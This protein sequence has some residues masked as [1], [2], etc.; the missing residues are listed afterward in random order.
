MCFEDHETAQKILLC[1][2]PKE[3]KRL[4]R[5]VRNFDEDIWESKCYD[6]VRR[7]NMLKV[8]CIIYLVHLK[9]KINISYG[10]EK[11]GILKKFK[12]KT[13]FYKK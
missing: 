9:V 10:F 3:M 2:S 4:G 7:G 11:V 1:E 12:S 13:F 8:V 5:I 6:I